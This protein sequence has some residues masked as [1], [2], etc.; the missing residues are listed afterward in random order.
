MRKVKR[1]EIKHLSEKK[2]YKSIVKLLKGL[3][4]ITVYPTRLISSIYFD[5][6]NYDSFIDSEEGLVPRKKVRLRTYNKIN[7]M[8]DCDI[9]KNSFNL[10][11]KTAKENYDEKISKLYNDPYR[12]LKNGI[13]DNDLGHCMPI[14]KVTY[15]RDYYYFKGSIVTLDY[16]LVYSKILF[17]Q[18]SNLNSE[19][20]IVEFK[21][22]SKYINKKLF[23]RCGFK[24]IRFSKYSVA[25]LKTYL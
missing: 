12:L 13:I 15:F 17:D 4:A 24:S 22:N 7:S 3:N 1:S 9:K 20:M 6:K 23:E 5:N 25:Y 8:K 14:V 16:D 18:F 21:N 19:N 10:E 2:N 11:I